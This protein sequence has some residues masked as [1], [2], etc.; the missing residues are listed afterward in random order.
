MMKNRINEKKNFPCVNQKIKRNMR[1]ILRKQTLQLEWSGVTPKSGLPLE[2]SCYTEQGQK[3]DVRDEPSLPMLKVSG[4]PSTC[5]SLVFFIMDYDVKGPKNYFCHF[6]RFN[7]PPQTKILTMT[8]GVKAENDGKTFG[9]FPICPPRGEKH[10][11]YFRLLALA[12]KADFESGVPWFELQKWISSVQ[13]LEETALEYSFEAPAEK[14]AIF[15]GS[16]MTTPEQAQVTSNLT[17]KPIL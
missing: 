1:P 16:G 6:A 2:L 8:S 17:M 4:V 7:I 5:Q 15:T 10:T 9:F 12:K 13:L 14:S 3:K 11:Y